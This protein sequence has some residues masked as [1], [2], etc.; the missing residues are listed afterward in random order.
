MKIRKQVYELTPADLERF[1]IWEYALDEEGEEGQDEATVR[2][3]AADGELEAADGPFM[4]R[5]AFRLADGTAM[6]GYLTPSAHA[7]VDLGMIQP[8]IVTE[9]GQVAF[10]CGVIKPDASHLA[11]C[12]SILGKAANEIFP[13][14][15]ASQID[16]AKEP[17][18]G[19]VPGFLVL[20]DVS[21]EKVKVVL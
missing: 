4:V 16:H 19:M 18:V 15:F 6:S 12:Y 10:W 20:E 1:P 21:S 7:Q 9:R 5:A 14:S 2:P 13:V 3:F 8:V 17:V 11:E